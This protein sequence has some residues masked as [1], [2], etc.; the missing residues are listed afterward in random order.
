MFKKGKILYI[1]NGCISILLCIFLILSCTVLGAIISFCYTHFFVTPM[2]Q[3][4]ATI[5]V[6]ETPENETPD[7]LTSSD[8]SAS[9]YLVKAYMILAKSDTVLQRAADE[10]NVAD[11]ANHYTVDELRSAVSTSQTNNTVIF[12]ITVSH[13]DGYEAQ[14]IANAVATALVAEGPNVIKGTSAYII[15][16][17]RTTSISPDYTR[18]VLTGTG[19][20]AAAGL[21]LSIPIIAICII[22]IVYFKRKSR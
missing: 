2:Y 4:S 13:K 16:E 10:L 20:G 3:S 8:L 5:Y 12:D 18:N 22:L 11:E 9:M 21:I 7:S 19:I 6:N 1:L 14:T 17:A 15:D